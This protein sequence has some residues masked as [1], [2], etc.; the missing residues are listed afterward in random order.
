MNDMNRLW[1]EVKNFVSLPHTEKQYAKMVNRLD[2]L[3]D[4][5]G[6][7]ENHPLATLIETIG[8]LIEAYEIQNLVSPPKDSIYILKSLMTEHN[9]KQKDMNEIGSQGVVSEV[10]NGRRKLNLRQISAIAKRF[11]LSVDVFI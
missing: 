6:N 8:T 5:I 9:L 1:P 10:L 11:H 3:I 7:D 4:E 2:G